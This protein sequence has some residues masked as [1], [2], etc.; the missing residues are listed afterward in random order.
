MGEGLEA[1]QGDGGYF[2]WGGWLG[3]G[4]HVTVHS[5][6]GRAR[7]SDSWRG[8]FEVGSCHC[9]RCEAGM[10]ETRTRNS[11]VKELERRA[12]EGLQLRRTDTELT[13]QGLLVKERTLGSFGLG[14]AIGE[15]GAG[16]H[17]GLTEVSEGSC[18]S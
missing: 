2:K 17:H 15:G 10:C 8:T 14:G 13:E 9:S 6:G 5:N 4:R 1:Q 11:E 3:P 18:H 12:P 16:E 7:R